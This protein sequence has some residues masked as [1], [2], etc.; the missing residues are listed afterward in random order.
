MNGQADSASGRSCSSFRARSVSASFTGVSGRRSSQE[1]VAPSI[2]T[3]P[4]D[5]RQGAAGAAGLGPGLAAAAGA[6]RASSSYPGGFTPAAP[7]AG[8]PSGSTGAV[9]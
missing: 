9:A 1:T 2:E 4:T 3:A 5:Q 8:A 7:S 6:S